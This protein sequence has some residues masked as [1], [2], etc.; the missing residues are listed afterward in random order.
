MC[1]HDTFKLLHIEQLLHRVL[2][3][4]NLE[5]IRSTLHVQDTSF[6][7]RRDDT[8]LHLDRMEKLFSEVQAQ[9][10]QVSFRPT[11]DNSDVNSFF[12]Q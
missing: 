6:S 11:C 3:T 5:P 4:D 2:D 7:S 8:K 9:Q 1:Q 12:R 10:T